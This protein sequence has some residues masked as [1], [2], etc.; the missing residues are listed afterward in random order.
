ME[1]NSDII[2]KII[3]A[4]Q[5][6]VTDEDERKVFFKKLIKILNEGDNE[7]FVEDSMGIDDMYDE[8]CEEFSGPSAVDEDYSDDDLEGDALDHFIDPD[9]ERDWS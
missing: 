4:A 5:D 8:A 1:W 3:E 9:D 2:G 7:F 6:S